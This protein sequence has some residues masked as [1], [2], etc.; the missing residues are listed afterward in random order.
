MH[1]QPLHPRPQPNHRW[2]HH[3]NLRE[4]LAQRFELGFRQYLAMRLPGFPVTVAFAIAPTLWAVPVP[5]G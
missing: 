1:H 4:R 2:A 5:F 3:A